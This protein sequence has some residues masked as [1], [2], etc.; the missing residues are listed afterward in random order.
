MTAT[1]LLAHPLVVVTGKGGVG[2]SVVADALAVLA[3]ERGLDPIVVEIDG[4]PA[5][6][7]TGR[8][9]RRSIRARPAL[10]E[11]LRGR[12]PLGPLA[13]PLS[14]SRIFSA[15][16][17]T[18]PGLQQMLTIGKVWALAT[19]ADDRR[20]VILDAPSTGQCLALLG[21]PRTFAAVARTGPVAADGQ[22]VSAFLADPTR[23]GVVVVATPEDLA[24]TE[25]LGFV[26]DLRTA[27]GQRPAS[28]VL[29]G[30]VP[31]PLAAGDAEALPATAPPAMRRAA[32]FVAAWA[33]EQ[34]ATADRLVAGLGPVRVVSVPLVVSDD[35]RDVVGA[36][37]RGLDR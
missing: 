21:A 7:V 27:V 28:V 30:L 36:L 16:L 20:V 1:E 15:L 9:E 32:R 22:A 35:E 8:G 29:N 23:T 18:A 37:A 11:Y 13:S 6:A 5:A 10:E 34:R 19:A 25:T 4:A 3:R 2:K 12:L 33:D 26:A 24:V 17:A 14:R 31:D